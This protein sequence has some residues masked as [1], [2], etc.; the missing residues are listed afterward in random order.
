MIKDYL[1]LFRIPQWIK[2]LFVFVPIMFAQKLFDSGYFLTALE[3]FLIFSL[4]SSIVYT[5]NDTVDAEADKLHPKKKN[6]PI[7]SG[8]ISKIG[9]VSAAVVLTAIVITSL[10]FY[11]LY[12]IISVGSYLLLNICYSFF[13][14]HVVL[15]DIFSIAAGF[16]L[17]VI[18]GAFIIDVEISSWLILTTL[19]ISLFLGVMKRH[20]ELIRF[21]N[22]ENPETRKVLAFYSTDFTTQMA[23]VSASAVI[24][25][26]ALYTVA[27]RTVSVFHTENL[28]YT[29]PIVV[30]GIFR[31]MFLVYMNNKGENTTKIMLTD[32]AMISTV[33][34]YVF[35]TAFI[36]YRASLIQ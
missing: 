18:G 25:C 7:A 27:E 36:I 20:S 13:L 34:I 15:L 17:R 30:F 16:M 12:F 14:K 9:A 29:T 33:L 35:V 26:Y 6:R 3:G 28:I 31:Y 11:N 23:T 5:I 4:T 21:K 2:N 32:K 10:T 1:S 22:S 24:I 19:F 8:K